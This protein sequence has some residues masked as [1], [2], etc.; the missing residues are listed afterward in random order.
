MDGRE[1]RAAIKDI[2]CSSDKPITGAELASRFN[3]SRQV[4]VQDIAL[5]RSSGVSIV[6]TPSGYIHLPPTSYLRPARVFTCKHDTLDEVSEELMII[7][8]N[9][10]KVRDVI[11][12]HPVYG[13]MSGQLMISTEEGVKSLVN[14]LSKKNSA[15]LSS[16]TNGIHMHTV[17]A[18]SEQVLD[19]IE[20]ELIDAGIIK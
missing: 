11:I 19:T 12:E 13:E 10:G 20:Q 3:V 8:K 2:I 7:V 1:R 9:G 6:A 14:S 16:V 5:L 18:A 4:V 17:E 15:P